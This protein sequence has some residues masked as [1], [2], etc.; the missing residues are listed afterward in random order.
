MTP[1]LINDRLLLYLVT[2]RHLCGSRGVAATVEAALEGGVTMV[3]LRDPTASTSELCRS[4]LELRRIL[5]GTGVPLIV[6]DRLDVAF[7]IGADGVHLGQSDLHPIEARRL[8][9]PD[10]IIGWS[11]STV[12]ESAKAVALPPGTVDY[13][14]IGPVW[15][16]PTK[17]DTAPPLGLAGLTAAVVI[18]GGALPCVAIGGI[19]AENA[20]KVAATGVSGLAVVSA[21]C[22]APDPAAAAGALRQAVQARTG[23]P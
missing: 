1:Q 15:A 2:D 13:L 3:Q 12:G 8:A 5:L 17:T 11:V 20:A 19:N 18:V 6:N 23:H 14:G 21:I 10:L 22:G 9:G 4:G 7:A 16:T